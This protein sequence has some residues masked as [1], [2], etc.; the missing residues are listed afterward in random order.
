MRT[1]NYAPKYFALLGKVLGQQNN[2][3]VGLRGVI[4]LCM[5]S[6]CRGISDV[7]TKDAEAS[8]RILDVREE[9]PETQLERVRKSLQVK[10]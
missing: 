5:L 2:A 6:L 7:G 10:H 4:Q 9:K 3:F 1:L 8:D